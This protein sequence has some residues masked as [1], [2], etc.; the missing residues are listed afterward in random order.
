MRQSRLVIHPIAIFNFKSAGGGNIQPTRSGALGGC[1][2][3]EQ[4]GA[5]QP[6]F[7]EHKLLDRTTHRLE[8]SI[9]VRNQYA[10]MGD[11]NPFRGSFQQLNR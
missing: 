6:P 7:R 4:H 2:I 5:T 11:S 9:R 10:A 8:S 3:R 1:Q